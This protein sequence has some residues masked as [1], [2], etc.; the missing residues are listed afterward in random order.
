MKYVKRRDLEW[1]RVASHR[2]GAARAQVAPPMCEPSPWLLSTPPSG[3]QS[4][5]VKYNFLVFFWNFPDLLKYG[6][7]MVL[8][9]QNPDFG[10]KSSNDY[11]T[12]KNRGNNISIISKYEIY[13][14][15]IAN[16]DTK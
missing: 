4:L 9:Q 2:A 10:S 3:F 1:A 14:G 15:I 8:F 16:Y 11:Q 6:V 13:Q 12:C 7:L 5:L